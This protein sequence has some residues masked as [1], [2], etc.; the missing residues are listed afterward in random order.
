MGRARPQHRRHLQRHHRQLQLRPPRL[1]QTTHKRRN[2]DSLPARRTLRNQQQRHDHARRHQRTAG[3]DLAHYNG[4]PT[5]ASSVS[6]QYWNGH[7]DLAADADNTGARTNAYTYDPFGTPNQTTPTNTTTER[8]TGKWDK[9]LDTTSNLIEMGARPYD[10]TLG[11][12][13][14]TDPIDGGSLN[15]YDYAGQDPENQYDLTGTMLAGKDGAGGTCDVTKGSSGLNACMKS[16]SN[17]VAPSCDSESSNHGFIG[18]VNATV[19]VGGKIYGVE[20]GRG[21]VGLVS[22]FTT[23][24]EK[25]SVSVKLSADPVERGT[26]LQV[27]GEVCYLELCSF[28][29]SSSKEPFGPTSPAFDVGITVPG[30]TGGTPFVAVVHVWKP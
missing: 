2:N 27:G 23:A 17:C 15:P 29:G 24:G 1:P 8:W 11:R 26:Y 7:G 13:L 5:S 25:W 16:V 9:K 19:T 3:I 20:F 22:G 4:P 12:F 10:P 18:S 30:R 21:G 28:G 14:A 6:Y